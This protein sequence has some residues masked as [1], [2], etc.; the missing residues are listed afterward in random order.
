MRDMTVQEPAI[1]FGSVKK[2]FTF[3]NARPQTI[4][5][6]LISIFS[7]QHNREKQTL[8]AVNGVSFEVMPGESLGII[9]RNGSG[10]S[11]ILKLASGI[12]RP[13]DGQVLIRGRLS[14]LLELGAGFHPDLTGQENIYLNGSILGMSKEDVE[15]C[16]DSIVEFSELGEFINMPVKHYSSGMYMRLGFSVAV[17]VEPDILIIDE[18]L[19]VGDQ[20]FQS[21]CIDR[22]YEM[23]RKGTTIIIVSHNLNTIRALCSHI[24]W[25]EQ[26]LIKMS[27]PADDVIDAYLETQHGWRVRRNADGDGWDRWGTHEIELTGIDLLDSKGQVKEVFYPGDPIT[28]EMHYRANRPVEEPIFGLAFFQPDGTYVSGPDNRLAGIHL[29]VVTGNGVVRYCLDQL[30]LSPATYY[31]T[32]AIYDTDGQNP[33]D[34]HEKAYRFRVVSEDNQKYKGLVQFP[35]HWEWVKEQEEEKIL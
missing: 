15:G 6:T 29:G 4:L 17:H 26:G 30:L 12:I 11:T 28:I 2:S 14:A 24:L 22:I 31:L 7:R 34:H 33:Y 3:S 16:Y 13:S 18:I 35:A 9:G 21:K 27:G 20:S 8:W 25:V 32:A 5:E 19:A 1:R 23:K 10:K